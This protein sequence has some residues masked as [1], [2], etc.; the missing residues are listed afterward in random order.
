MNP[1]QLLQMMK[2]A[3]NPMAM[4]QQLAQNNPQLQPIIQNIQNKTPV[5]L[6]QYA[7]NLA[8]SRGIDLNKLLNQYGLSVR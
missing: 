8:Q 1:F 3:T 6:E 5:E 2:T 7:R 4:V